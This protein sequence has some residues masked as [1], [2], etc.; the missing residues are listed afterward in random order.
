MK[1]Q[2]VQIN[3]HTSGVLSYPEDVEVNNAELPAILYLH[4]FASNRDE[5]N[6]FY[7]NTAS[8]FSDTKGVSLRIDFSGFGASSM[9]MNESSITTMI[10]DSLSALRYL[11]SLNPHFTK[12]GIIGFSLG[13]AI[14]MLTT[15]HFQVD[16][17]ILISPALNLK[18]DLKVF[19]GDDN[20]KQ[21]V[22][23]KGSCKIALPW[24]ELELGNQFLNSLELHSPL[25]SVKHYMN[26]M[27]CIVGGNDFT[28]KNAQLIKLSS[29]S[30]E[31]QLK[32]I[33][34][35][36]HIFND[37]QGA[38]HLEDVRSTIWKF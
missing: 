27:L 12:I 25:S 33:D 19:L 18:Q 21:L 29:D 24:V 32:V 2:L 37:T 20:F 38:N 17:L 28:L 7:K 6:G 10:N 4:G 3:E 14:A 36:D 35:R 16:F 30:S 13:A 22:E 31:I 11:K 8:E 15:S 34:N 9:P 1:S 26:P 5:V 23:C